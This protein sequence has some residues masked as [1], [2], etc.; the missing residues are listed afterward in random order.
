MI[1]LTALKYSKQS[2]Q[3]P[4]KEKI[5]RRAMKWDSMNRLLFLLEL[6]LRTKN[7]LSNKKFEQQKI[8]PDI[9][10]KL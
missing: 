8:G 1:F 3:N 7:S 2:I 9:A 5:F 6:M 10:I 4:D